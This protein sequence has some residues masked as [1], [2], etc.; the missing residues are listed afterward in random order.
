M[1]MA[2][3]VTIPFRCAWS[4]FS[5]GLDLRKIPRLSHWSRNFHSGHTRFDLFSHHQFDTLKVVKDL[6]AEGFTASQSQAVVKALNSVLQESLL[7]IRDSIVTKNAFESHLLKQA[8]SLDSL[9]KDMQILEK[10]EF[11]LLKYETEN[12]K[13]GLIKLS[14]QLK[15]EIAKMKAGVRLDM[16]LE[17]SRVRLESLLLTFPYFHLLPP[18]QQQND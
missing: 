2:R 12:V 6:E 14:D 17:K 15:D 9:R 10:S 18:P 1:P 13:A 7:G 3:W 16:S 4:P 5:H 8:A 11:N